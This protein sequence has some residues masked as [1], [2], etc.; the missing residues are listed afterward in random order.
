MPDIFSSEQPLEAASLFLLSSS[1]TGYR[2]AINDFV[3][4]ANEICK[5]HGLGVDRNAKEFLYA[6][7]DRTWHSLFDD[8]AKQLID[9]C[10]KKEAPD[11][12]EDER[13]V[14]RGRS[15]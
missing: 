14:S 6:H 5:T 10:C 3:N 4:A 1:E 2:E 9:N 7:E 15:R 12:A 13:P 8:V 11:L